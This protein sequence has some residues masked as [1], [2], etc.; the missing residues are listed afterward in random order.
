MNALIEALNPLDQF[1]SSATHLAAI[2]A[3]K[4]VGWRRQPPSQLQYS[5]IYNCNGHFNDHYLSI[6]LIVQ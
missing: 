3:F 2:V 5:Q 1:E 6:V 4:L